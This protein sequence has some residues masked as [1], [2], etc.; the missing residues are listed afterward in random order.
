M[1]KALCWAQI[2]RKMRQSIIGITGADLTK[3]LCLHLLWIKWAPNPWVNKIWS[4]LHC[5][6]STLFC[7]RSQI[8]NTV[9]R[10]SILPTND[11]PHTTMCYKLHWLH[12]IQLLPTSWS[13]SLCIP[14]WS[15]LL[16]YFPN[17]FWLQPYIYFTFTLPILASQGP[18]F[19]DHS[20]LGFSCC[21]YIL[22][23]VL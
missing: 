23:N 14:A 2:F 8:G 16:L 20:A 5:P 21:A 11:Q 13:S 10:E 12:H 7:K 6:N 22:C 9:G 18:L 4:G 1:F 17:P 19:S 15:A 3:Q